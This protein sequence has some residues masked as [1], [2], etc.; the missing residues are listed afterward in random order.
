MQINPNNGG[1][2][3]YNKI[4]P[5]AMLVY[6]IMTPKNTEAKDDLFTKND[7]PDAMLVYGIATPKDESKNDSVEPKALLVYGIQL[8]KAKD[9]MESFSNLTSEQKETVSKLWTQIMDILQNK[10]K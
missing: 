9:L 1:Q 7:A 10:D 5:E 2:N 4:N 3:N 6:G 8:P